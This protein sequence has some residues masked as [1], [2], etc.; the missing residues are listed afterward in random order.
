MAIS[1]EELKRQRE[2]IQKHLN[3]LDT[4]IAELEPPEAKPNSETAAAP[5]EVSTPKVESKSEE[6]EP[7]ETT[8]EN[9]ETGD[10][11][12]IAMSPEIEGSTYKA[13]TQDELMRAKVGCFVLFVLGCLL[14]LFLLFGLPY[15]L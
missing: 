12:M 2:Q 4:K 5:K 1:L 15:L 11:N 7:T 3:W 6:A 8:P 14:F 9:K 10:A 13:K